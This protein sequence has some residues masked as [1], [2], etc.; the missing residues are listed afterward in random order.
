MTTI[1][2]KHGIQAET[3]SSRIAGPDLQALPDFA[4]KGK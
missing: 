3:I 1:R 4:F 2:T